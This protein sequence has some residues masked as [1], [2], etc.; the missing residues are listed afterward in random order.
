MSLSDITT[1]RLQ[2]ATHTATA[3]TTYDTE[4]RGAIGPLRV[5]RC[6]LLAPDPSAGGLARGLL[7]PRH[8]VPA[9]IEVFV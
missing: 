5:E 8:A 6:E 2:L 4:S 1:R 9:R 7:V 3:H